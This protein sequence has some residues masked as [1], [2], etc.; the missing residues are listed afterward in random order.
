MGE[1][2]LGTQ[3]QGARFHSLALPQALTRAPQQFWLGTCQFQFENSIFFSVAF[4]KHIYFLFCL[5][6]IIT[7]TFLT[8][9][10]VKTPTGHF[11]CH[12]GAVGHYTRLQS[13]AQITQKLQRLLPFSSLPQVM[14]I[15]AS[16]TFPA[17]SGHNSKIIS[18]PTV[19]NERVHCIWA[20]P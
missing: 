12:R 7:N 11:W 3:L 14:V 16:L 18:K 2:Y 9:Y 10:F 1:A 15:S 20:S 4:V 19:I 8:I 6:N 5:C 17:T 13:G